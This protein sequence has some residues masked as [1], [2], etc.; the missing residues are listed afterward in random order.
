MIQKALKVVRRLCSIDVVALV[1]AVWALCATKHTHHRTHERLNEMQDLLKQGISIP[2][3]PA[4][5][6]RFEPRCK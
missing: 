1:I 4:P 3:Q 2:E 6:I 5:P